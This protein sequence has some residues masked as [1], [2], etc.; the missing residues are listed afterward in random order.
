MTAATIGSRGLDAVGLPMPLPGIRV[1]TDPHSVTASGKSEMARFDGK[2]WVL[3]G[4][5]PG[6]K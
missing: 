6:E 4:D 5:I 1:H 2:S 3:F